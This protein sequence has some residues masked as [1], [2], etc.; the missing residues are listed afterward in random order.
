M[1][2]D[3]QV[4]YLDSFSFDGGHTNKAEIKKFR[5][6]KMFAYKHRSLITKK[7]EELI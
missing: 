6:E 7:Y 5:T 1:K 4:H 2:K 3:G